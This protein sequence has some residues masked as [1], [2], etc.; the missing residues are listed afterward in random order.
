[1]LFVDYSLKAGNKTTS[2]VAS[3]QK[4]ATDRHLFHKTEM[5]RSTSTT[6]TP[7]ARRN[8]RRMGHL[9]R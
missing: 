5:A 3:A 4:G 6:T 9:I 8:G 1:M 2:M 7:T